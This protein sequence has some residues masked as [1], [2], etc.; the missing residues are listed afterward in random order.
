MIKN[1]LFQPL[2]EFIL[3]TLS[4]LIVSGCGGSKKKKFSIIGTGTGTAPP[5]PPGAAVSRGVL[6]GIAD[7]PGTSLDLDYCD[8]DAQVLGEMLLADSARWNL[9]HGTMLLNADAT[10]ANIEAAIKAMVQDAG[11]DDVVLFF[12]SGHGDT[13][14]DYDGDES[15][16]LDEELCFYDGDVTDD[17]LTNWFQGIQSQ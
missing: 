13:E 11:P 4:I 10:I 8:D 7:Y 16:G 12:Y 17:T 15:D 9:D 14:T 1:L 2:R 6:V 5:P 3:L